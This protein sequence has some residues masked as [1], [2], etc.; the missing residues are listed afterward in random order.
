VRDAGESSSERR[1][2]AG[3]GGAALSARRV[4][5]SHRQVREEE[6]DQR[7]WS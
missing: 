1:E 7:Q 2:A 4:Q 5:V 3:S 6:P